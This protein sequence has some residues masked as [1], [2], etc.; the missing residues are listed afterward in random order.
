MKNFGIIKL[1]ILLICVVC[2]TSCGKNDVVN[3]EENL[4]RLGAE[5]KRE[6]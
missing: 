4:A 2:F 1:S 5:I 6:V 3:I